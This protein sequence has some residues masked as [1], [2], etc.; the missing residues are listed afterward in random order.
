MI[1]DWSRFSGSAALTILTGKYVRFVSGAGFSPELCTLIY[2]LDLNCFIVTINILLEIVLVKFL[3]TNVWCNIGIANDELWNRFLWSANLLH[4][5]LLCLSTPLTGFARTAEL[6]ICMDVPPECQDH[7]IQKPQGIPDWINSQHYVLLVLVVM[8]VLSWNSKK[9]ERRLNDHFVNRFGRNSKFGTEH[10]GVTHRWLTRLVL[11]TVFG[12]IALE[13]WRIVT[14]KAEEYNTL[15][16]S[17]LF[18]LQELL[19]CIFTLVVLPM[20]YSLAEQKLKAGLVKEL[21]KMGVPFFKRDQ[22]SS[23]VGT[24]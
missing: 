24:Q 10:V 15:P 12:L 7:L 13:T 18:A 1:K 9:T 3:Y 5:G 17:T 16:G 20:V 11:L 14:M 19:I 6:A 23:F 2:G 21:E 8:L 22:V 4:L